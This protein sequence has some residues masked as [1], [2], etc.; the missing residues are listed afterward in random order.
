MA[1]TVARDPNVDARQVVDLY[2]RIDRSGGNIPMIE[3]QGGRFTQPVNI[4]LDGPLY[5]W[6]SLKFTLD[7]SDPGP[8]SPEFT[9]PFTLGKSAVLRLRS[10]DHAGH[11]GPIVRAQF[12]VK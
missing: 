12:I 1:V 5:H 4:T 11:G 3:P 8:S 7:G 9:E 10:F 2:D 6:G